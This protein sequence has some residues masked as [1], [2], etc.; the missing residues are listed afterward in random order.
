MPHAISVAAPAAPAARRVGAAAL[1]APHRILYIEANQDGTVGGSHRALYDLVRALDRARYEPVVMFYQDNPYV[2]RLRAQ[3]VE[4]RLYDRVKQQEREV[5]LHGNRGAKL[6]AMATAV[7]RRWRWLRDE[8]I[9]LVHVNNSPRTGSDD[10]LPAARLRGVPII[11]NV[12][13][14]ARGES[15][16]LRRHL[17]RAFDH[18]LPISHYITEAMRGHGIAAARMD[19]VYL[20]VDLGDFRGRVRRDRAAVRAELGVAPEQLLAVMVG[21]LREWK[22][23]HVVLE[24]MRRLPPEARSALHVAFAGAPTPADLPYLERLRGMVAEAGLEAQVS[25]LGARDDVPDLLHA[26]DLALHA[27][28]LPEPFGLV[29]V[30]AM[31]AGL[32][33]IAARTGGPGE[34][35]TPDSGIT[36]DPAEPAQLTEALGGLLASAERRAALRAG[37]LRRVEG[38]TTERYAAGVQ[39]VYGR[40]LAG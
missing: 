39:A 29:V 14:D 34:V 21:N 28:V 24:A 30:E 12:M 22:G 11:A 6:R 17:F 2:A 5:Y 3:G 9:D 10:W 35:I 20:G 7:A 19:L 38:F 26:A 36:F 13:G 32:P 25:F 16:R 1:A 15:G 27:S 8:H 31:A 18:Y 33:V 4:V 40:I 37:A 23:Q